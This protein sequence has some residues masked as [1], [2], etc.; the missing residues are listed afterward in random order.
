MFEDRVLRKLSGSKEEDVTGDWRTFHNEQLHNSHFST[1]I[2]AIKSRNM[3]SG[4]LCNAWE[5][6][7]TRRN[8]SKKF[9]STCSYNS[10]YSHL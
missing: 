1:D 6:L 2:R 10:F 8:I 4:G 3:R 7:E 9:S 5:G